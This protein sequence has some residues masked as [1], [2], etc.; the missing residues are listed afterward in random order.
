L[1]GIEAVNQA[2][3]TSTLHVDKILVHF[4]AEIG[5]KSRIHGPLIMHNANTD[6]SKLKIGERV[7]IGRNVCFDLTEEIHVGDEAV[8]SMNCVLLTHSDV[9]N[10]FLS[11]RYPRF[12]SPLQIGDKS[13]LGAGVIVLPGCHIGTASVIGAG[14]VGTEEI[15]EDVTAAG[16]PAKIVKDFR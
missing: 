6:Y 4:G 9:G 1:L 13:Y 10:R 11:E 5:Q 12:I 7:H 3:L 15:P 16:V 8:I 14:S 2:L